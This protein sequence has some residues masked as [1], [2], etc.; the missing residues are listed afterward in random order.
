MIVITKTGIYPDISAAEYFSDPTPTPSLSQ[1][2]AKLLIERSPAHARLAHPRLNPNYR[3]VEEGYDKAK[4]IGNAAHAIVLGR[5]KSVCVIEAD[6][7]K[8][9]LA[10]ET[11]DKAVTDGYVPILAKHHKA[12]RELAAA[13]H[14]QLIDAGCP[15]AFHDGSAEVCIAWEEDG[16][17]FR[18][19]VDWM[20]TWATYYDL[21]TGATSA[22]PHAIPY[23]MADQG[24]AIQAAFQERGLDVLDPEDAGR[25]CF[26]FVAVENEPPY[27]LTVHELSEAVMT[28]GRKQVDH[29]VRIWRECMERDTWPMYPAEINR[30]EYPGHK[31]N[32]WL[33]REVAEDERR[34]RGHVGYADAMR[35]G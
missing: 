27:A 1:S 4:A 15:D 10:Q 3:A 13:I 6:N 31:E 7:F 22:A 18:S 21:K 12:A 34:R 14:S 30:P 35:A 29:A 23:R 11:R 8:T 17:W 24:W 28:L 2:V 26:R 33:E 20:T 9:K 32:Q 19:L 16:V 5:G 25:R